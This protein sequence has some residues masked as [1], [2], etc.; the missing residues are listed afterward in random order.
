MKVTTTPV[1]VWSTEIDDQPGGLARALRAITE[2]GA[3]L[4]YVAAERQPDG[5]RKGVLHVASSDRYLYL[6]RVADVGLKR[7]S[8]CALLKI[9]GSDEPGAGARITRAMAEAG[10]S[11]RGFAGTVAGH[12]FVC[13]AEFDNI[14][15]RTKAD[16]ALKA[17]NSHPAW[18]FWSRHST[19]A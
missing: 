18:A 1:E 17:L 11:L 3:N 14:V 4:D 13:Y 5:S 10:V 9:E 16:A 15:D 2:F 7:V 6:D 12:H 19:A 8:D